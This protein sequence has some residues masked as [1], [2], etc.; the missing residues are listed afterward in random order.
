MHL[1][2]A[3]PNDQP[4]ELIP[5]HAPSAEWP[6]PL[7]IYIKIF[8]LCSVSDMERISLVSKAFY[9]H[10]N[11]ENLWEIFFKNLNL[12]ICEPKGIAVKWKEFYMIKEFEKYTKGTKLC[13]NYLRQDIFG[14]NRVKK[15]I[16]IE[17]D[18]NSPEV[19]GIHLMQIIKKAEGLTQHSSQIAVSVLSEEKGKS[20]IGIDDNKFLKPYRLKEDSF[21]TFTIQDHCPR[22]RNSGIQSMGG[23]L[24]G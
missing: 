5:A 4:T 2:P 9:K 8:S 7:E 3:K 11:D 22:C 16:E 24:R 10:A 14:V 1:D 21:L 6:F 19:T 23:K 12:G 18:L 15:T 17:V 20:S 13:F